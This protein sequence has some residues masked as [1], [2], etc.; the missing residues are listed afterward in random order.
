MSS[1]STVERIDELEVIS[2][3]EDEY[4]LGMNLTIYSLGFDMLHMLITTMKAIR[5]SNSNEEDYLSNTVVQWTYSAQGLH[6]TVAVLLSHVVRISS[7]EASLGNHSHSDVYPALKYSS[8]EVM[9]MARILLGFYSP[10]VQIETLLLVCQHVKQSQDRVILPR[11]LDFMR[12]LIMKL[13]SN[14]E[15]YKDCDIAVH[16]MKVMQQIS[17]LLEIF[18]LEL[19]DEFRVDDDEEISPLPKDVGVFMSMTETYSAVFAIL[20]L[21]KM[22]ISRCQTEEK[23]VDKMALLTFGAIVEWMDDCL[24]K[25]HS[26]GESL[27]RFITFCESTAESAEPPQDWHLLY[28]LQLALRDVIPDKCHV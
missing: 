11:A 27:A 7:L 12:T 14:I 10:S 20:R 13:C 18:L 16:D 1:S 26:F 23:V 24:S 25:L 17:Q 22:W 6:S 21:Q 2:S 5:P 4:L 28:L 8:V 3:S 19:Y 15:K 9:N